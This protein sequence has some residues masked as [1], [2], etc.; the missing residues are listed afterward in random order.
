MI[1]LDH[2]ATTPV[3][4]D[5]LGAMLPYFSDDF[6]VSSGSACAAGSSEVSHVL[7]GLGLADHLARATVRVVVGRATTPEDVDVA[8]AILLDTLAVRVPDWVDRL[9]Y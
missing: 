4:P 6:A 2:A 9:T 7:R 1:Y 5:V 8:A 3:D